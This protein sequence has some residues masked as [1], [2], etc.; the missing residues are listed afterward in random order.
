M[1]L[2]DFVRGRL[3]ERDMDSVVLVV[4]GFGVRVL[5]TSATLAG[6]P[7]P[8]AEATVYTY[9]LVREDNLAL[10][11]FASREERATFTQLLT[12]SG[13]GP[14]VAINALSAMSHDRL[15]ASIAGGDITALSR[16]PGIGKKTAQRMVIDLKGKL[17]ITVGDVP[18]AVGQNGVLAETAKAL[19]ALGFTSAEINA[20]LRALPKDTEMST[21]TAVRIAMRGI[22]EGK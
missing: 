7:E 22:R 1:S 10:Y 14:K 16:L 19:E 8:G 6:L 2:I 18:V 13:V 4:G 17:D 9:L 3:A 11:G 5:V 12:V 21:D 20:G 15:A